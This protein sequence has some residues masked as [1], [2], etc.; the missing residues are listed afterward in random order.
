MQPAARLYVNVSRAGAPLGDAPHPEDTHCGFLCHHF[1]PMRVALWKALTQPDTS[2]AATAV[3][4]FVTATVALSIVILCLE[5]MAAVAADAVVMHRLTRTEAAC[6]LVFTVEYLAKLL[7]APNRRAFALEPLSVLDLLSIAPW[8]VDVAICRDLASCAHQAGLGATRVRSPL[9]SV[10]RAQRLACACGALLRAACPP[11]AQRSAL[12]QPHL[13]A[14]R[15]R[16]APPPPLQLLRVFRLAR[17][18]RVL[19]L[20]QRSQRLQVVRR[21]LVQSTD[22]VLMLAFCLG[23]AILI[24]SALVYEAER[25]QGDSSRGS[26]PVRRRM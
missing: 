26:S 18:F 22:V 15:P 10:P 3:A 7:A 11:A 14:P 2:W 24:F 19:K 4:A 8:Y 17:V 21:A 1:L 20:G 5:T 23:L 16:D 25:R 9:P 6:M 12:C 13:T